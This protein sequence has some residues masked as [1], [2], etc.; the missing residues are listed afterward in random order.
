MAKINS[1][2]ESLA[3]NLQNE[4]INKLGYDGYE[5]F[6]KLTSVNGKA[7]NPNQPLINLI[8]DEYYTTDNLYQ[9]GEHHKN[10]NSKLTAL[11]M[12][13]KEQEE[14]DYTNMLQ[15]IYFKANFPFS[16]HPNYSGYYNF[17]NVPLTAYKS[18]KNTRIFNGAIVPAYINSEN[19]T[20]L[21]HN[22][23]EWFIG[24]EKKFEGLNSKVNS[25]SKVIFDLINIKSPY[26]SVTDIR[27]ESNNFIMTISEFITGYD[28]L[29]DTLQDNAIG[30]LVD[31]SVDKNLFRSVLT[32]WDMLPD[33]GKTVEYFYNT[34]QSK[35]IYYIYFKSG[36]ILLIAGSATY[37]DIDS[38]HSG[39]QYP[40]TTGYLDISAMDYSKVYSSR[41]GQAG[42]HPRFLTK[43]LHSQIV[44]LNPKTKPVPGLPTYTPDEINV[45]RIVLTPKY[46]TATLTIKLGKTIIDKDEYLNT[47][48]SIT[49]SNTLLIITKVTDLEYTINFLDNTPDKTEAIIKI[50]TTRQ[51]G[52]DNIYETPFMYITSG[53]ENDRGDVTPD[54]GGGGGGRG[55]TGTTIINGGK[56]IFPGT[57]SPPNEPPKDPK[58]YTYI[59]MYD[60]SGFYGKIPDDWIRDNSYSVKEGTFIEFEVRYP[61][62]MWYTSRKRLFI[63]YNYITN[64]V[65]LIDE[66]TDISQKSTYMRTPLYKSDENYTPEYDKDMP[67][68]EDYT[69][70]EGDELLYNFFD[71]YRNNQYEDTRKTTKYVKRKHFE[72]TSALETFPTTRIW[73]NIEVVNLKALGTITDETTNDP[74]VNNIYLTPTNSTSKIRLGS[75]DPLSTRK[76]FKT[77]YLKIEW[78][79]DGI[80][81]INKEG[82]NDEVK[83]MFFIPGSNWLKD[84]TDVYAPM[85]VQNPGIYGSLEGKVK[86][87]DKFYKVISL[88]EGSNTLP[89]RRDIDFNIKES[90]L[91][92]SAAQTY[93]L[94][95]EDGF[96]FKF[97][98]LEGNHIIIK[99]ALN[100]K[101]NAV[102]TINVWFEITNWMKKITN[103]YV[104]TPETHRFLVK[105]SLMSHKPQQGNLTS[106]KCEYFDKNTPP[107]HPLK[108]VILN[109]GIYNEAIQIEDIGFTT[110][111]ISGRL[112]YQ[113]LYISP[114][115][116]ASR[117][118]EGL[119]EEV[120]V[121]NANT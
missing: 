32:N 46:N 106:I 76:V 102:S 73:G 108:E 117:Y 119:F 99:D 28:T 95:M 13:K 10:Y 19:E 52:T 89:H 80:P 93:P 31:D 8:S 90:N 1:I 55:E 120:I 30:I 60:N 68:F 66:D 82:I 98:E 96:T 51:D 101:R 26:F 2:C 43:L 25:Y 110:T 24:S 37:L 70:K 44:I 63:N 17:A 72:A 71:G 113:M 87:G 35:Y 77:A 79:V 14:D 21:Y 81:F 4:E 67:E 91:K 5:A 100:Y 118:E 59:E 64:V 53:A 111:Y 85:W 42:F 94:E 48:K 105:T 45:T 114:N 9:H 112:P 18:S 33:E 11:E 36:D 88:E 84:A 34:I 107:N 29:N 49:S 47:F 121:K 50:I 27:K 75:Y 54:P 69:Y 97:G 78:E 20:E 16:F 23:W 57:Y 109:T 6:D 86:I 39:Q 40:V 7:R 3:F 103:D 41:L 83:G 62:S 74:N 12:L 116:Q 61:A 56:P 92:V 38:R 22:Y 65:G 58:D 104:A 115:I 15:N